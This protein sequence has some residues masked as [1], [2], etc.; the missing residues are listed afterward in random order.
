MGATLEGKT[1]VLDVAP[2]PVLV[3]ILNWNGWEETLKAVDSVLGQDYA[4]L[5]VLVIDNGSTDGSAARLRMIRDDRV[6]L[7]ELAQNR[8]FTGGC[9]E[10]FKHALAADMHYVWLFNSDA[11]IEGDRRAELN[12]CD[13]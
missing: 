7:L 9:N 6:E 3:V 2:P 11:V 13:C 8:G 4:D 5:R 12:R 1:S 10:G